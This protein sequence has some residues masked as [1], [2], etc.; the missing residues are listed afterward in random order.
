MDKHLSSIQ[1]SRA[2]LISTCKILS[3]AF[4][5]CL[6]L[7]C[8]VIAAI[9]AYIAAPPT[10][11]SYIGPPSLLDLSPF[12][13]SALAGGFTIFLLWRLFREI[14][15]GGSPFTMMRVRQIQALGILFFITAVCNLLIPPNGNVGVISGDAH[16]FLNSDPSASDSA[17]VDVTSFMTAIVCFALSLVF[18]Y[19][20]ALECEADDLV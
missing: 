17:T 10:G 14:G 3:V 12:I 20:A 19:G 5:I 16:M 15:G 6:L 9:F 7:Y 2:R 11:F 8:V 18:K 4:F 1:R 13:L